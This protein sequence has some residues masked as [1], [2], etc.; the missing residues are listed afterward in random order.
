M[1]WNATTVWPTPLNF[2]LWSHFVA[3]PERRPGQ[4][5]LTRLIGAG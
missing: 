1:P 2:E 4:V 5:E 3:D